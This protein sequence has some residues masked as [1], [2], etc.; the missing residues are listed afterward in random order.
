MRSRGDIKQKLK[1]ASFRHLKRTLRQS[2][3]PNE[4]WDPDEIAAI[5]AEFR[6]F[7]AAAP[8]HEIARNYP[9]VAALM[10]VLSEDDP[11]NG[12]LVPG[13]T[14]VGSLDDVLLWADTP[15]EAGR[16]REV[17][18]A[19]AEKAGEGVQKTSWWKGLFK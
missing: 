9:D 13:A 2:L 1:Q 11:V 8:V 10:W 5:K 3:P 17:L 18:D 4:D 12:G 19:L 16:A 14:L 6:E 7:M 15:E